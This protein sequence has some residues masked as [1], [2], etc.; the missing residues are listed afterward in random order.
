MLVQLAWGSLITEKFKVE[1]GQY[2][3]RGLIASTIC[4]NKPDGQPEEKEAN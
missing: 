3:Q 1:V 4:D 2:I